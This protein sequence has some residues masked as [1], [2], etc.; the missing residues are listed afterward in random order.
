MIVRFD[1]IV[2]KNRKKITD[3]KNVSFISL[4]LT[5]PEIELLKDF[6]P[7]IGPIVYRPLC[8][9]GGGGVL[10]PKWTGM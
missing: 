6:A 3:F 2:Q 10:N 9:A 7:N 1:L 8:L 4:S 5:V